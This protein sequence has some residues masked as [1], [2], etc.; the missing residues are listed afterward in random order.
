[1]RGVCASIAAHK[2]DVVITEKG[3]SDLAAHYLT[4]AG[5]SAVR[6]LR[7]TDNNRIARACGAT[8]VHRPEEIR[9]SDIGTK[10]GLFEVVKVGD[11]FWTFVVDCE[12]CVLCVCACALCARAVFAGAPRRALLLCVSRLSFGSLFFLARACAPP[13][14]ALRSLALGHI[15]LP[16][17]PHVSTSAFSTTFRRYLKATR[18]L[19]AL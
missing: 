19:H 9:E 7:K 12:V 11:E 6:R 17:V 4:K 15:R 3:L 13:A 10:A 18:W 16:I 14:H 2:P 1:M 5:I 8:I